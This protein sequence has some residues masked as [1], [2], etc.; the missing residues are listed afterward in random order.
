MADD[1]SDKIAYDPEGLVASYS[2][3]GKYPDGVWKNYSW[4]LENVDKDGEWI[5]LEWDGREAEPYIDEIEPDINSLEA[6]R[7]MD[8]E[9]EDIP[10]NI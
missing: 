8:E 1:I 9:D 2:R 6:Y 5:E 7:R 10:D 3:F 4:E